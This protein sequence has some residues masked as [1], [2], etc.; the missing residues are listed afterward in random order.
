MRIHVRFELPDERE[1]VLTPGD[2]IGRMARAARPSMTTLTP[3]DAWTWT[4]S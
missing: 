4:V 2:I 3:S 1:V